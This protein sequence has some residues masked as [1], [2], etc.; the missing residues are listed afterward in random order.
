MYESFNFTIQQN[1]FVYIS[2]FVWSFFFFNERSREVKLLIKGYGDF[3]VKS[4]GVWLPG[5]KHVR[6]CLPS[7]SGSGDGGHA[8]Y[9]LLSSGETVL[10]LK[11]VL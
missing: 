9:H 3:G 7:G 5:R 11:Y 10:I 4:G 2:V 8:P 1:I 6:L